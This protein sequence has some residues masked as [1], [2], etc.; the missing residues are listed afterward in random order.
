[1]LYESRFKWM[2][3]ALLFAAWIVAACVVQPVTM[4]AEA[5]GTVEAL[6]AEMQATVDALRTQVAAQL[7]VAP[8][9]SL[10]HI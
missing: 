4:P 2:L 7:Q 3:P 6:P 10:I 1:M 8:T 5:P 9:L